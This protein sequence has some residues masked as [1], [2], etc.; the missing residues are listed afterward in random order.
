M[1]SFGRFVNSSFETP[2]LF[3]D[4]TIVERNYHSIKSAMSFASVYYAVKAN[5]APEIL[6]ALRDLGSKFDTAS[7]QE[8]RLCLENG[9][10]PED[11]S[12]GST[13]KKQSAIQEAY[14][15]GVRIF[16]LDSQEEL[17]KIAQWASGSRI[18]CRLLVNNKGADWPLSRKFGCSVDNAVRLMSRA[19]SLG[20]IPYGLSFHVGSQ[21]TDPHAYVSAL[22]TLKECM[23]KLSNLGIDIKM[24]NLGGGYPIP[25]REEVTTIENFG[26]IIGR[27]LQDID[28]LEEIMIE[29][30]RFLVGTAGTIV[31]EVVLVAR[32][33]DNE[34]VR[35]VYLDIGRFGGLAETEGEAIKYRIEVLASQDTQ[36]T[37]EVILAGPTCDSTDTMYEDF[38][39]QLPVNLKSQDRLLIHNTGAYVTTYASQAFNGFA[40]LTEI[41]FKG[42][43]NE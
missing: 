23:G 31:T 12:F 41:Y 34:V 3:L 6:V 35:W 25:Y 40:P 7:I 21:Q 37:S 30:G 43:E 4:T 26:Q 22:E 39:Y 13:V 5:P 17:E 27:A 28:G 33:D 16:A 24:I 14:R 42:N 18:Y 11:I 9:I 8:V 38:K 36:E 20:L 1:T 2:I 19:T 15:L 10:L 29:P 32:K